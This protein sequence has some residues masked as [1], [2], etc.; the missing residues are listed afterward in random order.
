MRKLLLCALLVGGVSAENDA[1]PLSDAIGT[2]ITHLYRDSKGVYVGIRNKRVLTMFKSRA[3]MLGDLY[4]AL[5]DTQ[6]S[7]GARWHGSVRVQTD[8]KKKRVTAIE[9]VL[10]TGPYDLK[11]AEAAVIAA[12]KKVGLR[13]ESDHDDPHTFFDERKQLRKDLWIALG[14]GIIVFEVSI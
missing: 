2:I 8:D 3:N 7:P 5:A 1:K 13:L 11:A 9:I 4:L 6:Y 10:I 12:G 14:K